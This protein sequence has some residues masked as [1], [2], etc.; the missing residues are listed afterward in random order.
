MLNELS[1]TTSTRPR[2]TGM[3]SQFSVI[4]SMQQEPAVQ[5]PKVYL[6]DAT[7]GNIEEVDA[8]TAVV[9]FNKKEK[10]WLVTKAALNPSSSP[11]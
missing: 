11:Q 1:Y 8:L 7:G 6:H 10:K 2:F 9:S 4:R 5:P 3:I